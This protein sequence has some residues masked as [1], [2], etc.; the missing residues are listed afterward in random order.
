MTSQLS[1]RLSQLSDRLVSDRY[2]VHSEPSNH[3]KYQ[4][5][6][7]LW[8][9][10]GICDVLLGYCTTQVT[11]QLSDRL[12]QL[13]DRLS[14]LSDRLVSDPYLVH[15]EPSNH[16]K[17]HRGTSLCSLKG[18][19]YVLFGFCRIQVTSQLSDRLSQLSDRLVSDRYL[20]HS[21]PSNH[22]KYQM[23]TSF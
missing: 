7:S 15:L 22:R 20:V 12:S 2:L 23:G 11:S 17:F 4:I 14:Q 9:L 8:S 16:R 18:I 10:K 13:S 3:R 5:G 19:C 6:T 21:E 1:D